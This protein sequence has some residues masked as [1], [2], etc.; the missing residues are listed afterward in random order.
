MSGGL[1]GKNRERA[2]PVHSSRALKSYEDEN[3]SDFSEPAENDAWR[4]YAPMDAVACLFAF[5]SCF[6][7]SDC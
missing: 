6:K 7:Y 2:A 1:R 4:L 3:R 5:F